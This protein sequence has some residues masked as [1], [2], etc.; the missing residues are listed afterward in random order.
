MAKDKSTKSQ[1]RPERT[2]SSVDGISRMKP[3]KS[4]GGKK[5]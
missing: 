4:G 3:S 5:K 1:S 2:K